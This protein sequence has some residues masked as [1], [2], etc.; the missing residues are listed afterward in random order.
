MFLIGSNN[1]TQNMSSDVNAGN[2]SN[3]S[4]VPMLPQTLV[5]GSSFGL[6]NNS[7]ASESSSSMNDVFKDY[8]QSQKDISI[9][10][11]ASG[12]A[13]NIGMG[14]KKSFVYDSNGRL[15]GVSN[16]KITSPSPAIIPKKIKEVKEV[17]QNVVKIKPEKIVNQKPIQIKPEKTNKK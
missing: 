1:T 10:E 17:V 12:I 2:L 13:S 8:S 4:P 9:G 14:S 11:I 6:D 3:F 16:E 7:S 15:I 5:S